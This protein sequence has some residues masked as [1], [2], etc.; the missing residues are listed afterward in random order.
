VSPATAAA[1]PDAAPIATAV[2]AWYAEHGR[3]FLWRRPGMSAWGILLI[4]VM[5][6]QTQ[7]QRAADTALVWLERWP[8]P[9]ALAAAPVAEV[10]KAWGRL[11]YP[12]RAVAL[13]AAATAIA[14]R[15]GDVIPAEPAALLALPGIG[16]YTAHAVA[17]FAYG[18][19]VPVVDTNVRR[20]L[21]RAL[22]GVD[23]LAPATRRDHEL[24]DSILPASAEEARITNVAVMELGALLCTPRSPDCEHCPIRDACAWRAAGY[25][26]DAA[27]RRPAQARFEGSDR[28]LRGRVMAVLREADVPVP[29]TAFAGLDPDPDRIDRVLASLAAD[30]LA[31]ATEQGWALP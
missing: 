8:S 7:I 18:V 24:M 9:A 14:E 12:R 11:G 23:T 1:G 19:R 3:D 10:I 2:N 5:A 16:P 25:P 17:S 27:P 4:E 29:R 20:V 22:L 21:H 15:H 6:Q 26:A 13:H 31:A 28:Q 30:R